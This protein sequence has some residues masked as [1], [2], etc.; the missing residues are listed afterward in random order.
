MAAKFAGSVLT[1][2]LALVVAGPGSAVPLPPSPPA[3]IVAIGDLHG[4]H[5]VWIAIARGA[6]LIDPAGHWAGGKTTLVQ[7]GDIVDRGPQSLAIIRDLMRI[8]REAARAGGRVIVL[9]GNHEAMMVTG[10]LRYVDPGEYAA[11]V[12]RKS[13]RRRDEFYAARRNAIE[14]T[15]RA[16]EPGLSA[17]AIRKRVLAATPLG[18][19]EYE[20]A[21]AADGELGRWL[22][23]RPAVVRVGDTL[24][25]HGGL[26]PAFAAQP[27][28]QINRQVTAALVAR[29][30]A[31]TAII[32]DP[33]GPL[34]YR[35]LAGLTE[36]GAPPLPPRAMLLD[37]VLGAAHAKRIVIGH[38]PLLSGVAVTEGGRL[39]RLDSGASRF[40]GG[41]PGFVEI[42]A[43]GAVARNVVRPPR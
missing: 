23:G 29:D 41:V 21:W 24:F 9:V 20:A 7:T 36:A 39:V 11:F 38:T 19:V 10:D 40:Y 42:T 16:V 6:G 22:I 33:M 37:Q 28:D 3:R 2:A 12:D 26:S 18:K 43:A 25:V 4:D 15:A 27:I 8:E 35:G 5:D 30:E 32:N 14:A 34:W 31:P 1:I 17:T 13:E